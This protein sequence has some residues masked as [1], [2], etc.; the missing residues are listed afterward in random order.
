MSV[1]ALAVRVL[2]LDDALTQ[3]RDAIQA[4]GLEPPEMIE[5]D[6]RL[7]RFAS[8]GK[9]SDD[10]GWYVFHADGVPAGAFGDWRTSVSQTWRADIGRRLS[11]A[12][13]AA[14][15]ERIEAIKREREAEEA[16]QRAKARERAA[17]IWNNATPA[18][19]H[20]YFNAKGIKSHGLRV[21][22]GLLVVPMRD[23][24]ELHS[25]Q[26]ISGEGEKRFLT[27]GRV[28]GCYNSI[29]KPDGVLCVAEGYAT[30]AS[31][32]EAT[33]Y[34]VAVAF[35]AGNLL[36]AAQA[37]RAKFP[38]LRLIVCAD[39]DAKTEGNP[40]LTKAREAAQAVN[41][42]LAAPDFGANRPDGATDFNDLHRHAGPEAVRACIER[43]ATATP[44]TGQAVPS[45]VEI[46]DTV[47]RLA[48]LSPIKFDRVA[49]D[50]AKKLG[51]TLEALKKEVRKARGDGEGTESGQPFEI[52]NPEPWPDF[53]N[54]VRLLDDLAATFRRFVVLPEH[55]DAIAALWSLH[56]YAFELG[57]ITPI[58]V[59]CSPE[60][61]CGKTTLR[62]MLAQVVRSTLSTDGI[63]ASALFRVIEKWR[64]TVLL[65]DFDSWGRENEE[66]RG[67]LNTGYRK[68]GV[69]VRCV[70]DDQEPRAFVTYAPKC[71]N[72]IGRLHPTLY[73]RAVTITM[74]RK[75]RGEA[76]DS[77]H[78]FH[79]EELQRKS[80]RW[81]Q[82]NAKRIEVASPKMPEGLFNRQA[83]NWRPLLALAEVV[84]GHWPELAR[85]AAT[86][87]INADT[88]NES[89]GVMLLADIRTVFEVKE[90]DRLRSEDLL[91]A[92]NGLDERPWS[93]CVNGRP[94]NSRKLAKLLKPFEIR[95]D[96]IRLDDGKTPKGYLR[97]WFADAF[98]RYLPDE[99][100]AT[101]QQRGKTRDFRENL[102]A[103]PSEP[104]AD[105][106]CKK[107]LENRAC[108]GVA[109]VERG[110]NGWETEL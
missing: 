65:D 91:E 110:F 51:C 52:K 50:E 69:Y 94:M 76:V 77:L 93:E 24:Q 58:L 80:A 13:E 55:G 39:D 23:G 41:G 49:K 103:T 59:V 17:A 32:Y 64:P 29:G 106:K 31:I 43:A 37:M 7:H 46:A 72:L 1:P 78:G 85:Q 6:G 90:S 22:N 83:D 66:L 74:R 16:R 105:E 42:L 61:G 11:T 62:D 15:R 4:A 47:A 2:S 36:A 102:S 9:A 96:S 89:L 10:A 63:S 25:L 30:A 75:L 99:I 101:A 73:D 53:V 97:E 35:N 5:A 54:G 3:F 44:E 60:K 87:A 81:V 33:G 27:G 21:H 71:I 107:S 79:G 14:H 92:L 26:F 57:H 86:A 109:D 88:D 56:T 48:K 82:D 18:S 40:G 84:G 95:P 67:V 100:S 8:N 28:S 12:E 108:C 19:E 45:D 20:P 70:G 34:A 104:V 98:T 68:G 38:D